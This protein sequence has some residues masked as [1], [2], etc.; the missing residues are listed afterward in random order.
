MNSEKTYADERSEDL[1]TVVLHND[2]VTTMEFVVVILESIF[3]KSSDDAKRIM[4]DVHRKGVGVVGSY[5]NYEAES[6]ISQVKKLARA[7]NFPLRCAIENEGDKEALAQSAGGEKAREV[8]TGWQFF[9]EFASDYETGIDKTVFHSGDRCGFIKNILYPPRNFATLMQEFSPQAYH[10]K[11]LQMTVWIKTA[12]LTG[13]A[14]AWL[15]VDGHKRGKMLGFD[16]ECN[17]PIK[18]TVDWQQRQLVLDIPPFS[19]NIA[20]GVIL[21]GTGT[22]WIDDVVFEEVGKD[23]ATTDCPCSRPR[24]GAKSGPTNL[25][26][27]D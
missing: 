16:N 27:E 26:F 8:P 23:V 2:D 14:Q 3:G 12:D 19:T 4:L 13:H 17:R 6:K 21:N 24:R 22:V 15:R 18:G 20:F 25:S 5:K 11:R 1:S 9:G 10:D 7:A